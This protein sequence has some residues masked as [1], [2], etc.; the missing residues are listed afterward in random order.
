MA[1]M[2]CYKAK[3]GS[4]L[5]TTKQLLIKSGYPEDVLLSCN[6]EN[7]PTFHQKNSLLLKSLVYL[8][9]PGLEIFHQNL[10]TKLVKP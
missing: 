7:Q 5:E 1:A 6:K 10:K 9:L 2:I 8:K 4:K 3:L